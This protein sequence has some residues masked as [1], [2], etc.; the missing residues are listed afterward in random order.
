MLTPLFSSSP[1]FVNS[2]A[3]VI[4]EIIDSRVKGGVGGMMST[5]TNLQRFNIGAW[6]KDR[7]SDKQQLQRLQPRSGWWRLPSLH[8]SG[9]RPA[10][11]RT[12]GVCERTASASVHFTAWW[13]GDRGMPRR[14]PRCRVGH[15]DFS[16]EEVTGAC[17]APPGWFMSFIFLFK[18]L[19]LLQ[20]ISFRMLLFIQ[21]FGKMCLFRVLLQ[22]HCRTH[23][24]RKPYGGRLPTSD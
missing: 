1:F 23:V 20:A 11:V 9:P 15:F 22:S 3:Y 6:K 17:L 19:L 14:S 16:E 24:L 5:L 2:S 10:T 21:M 7:R 8:W 12:E 18:V 4:I 13:G